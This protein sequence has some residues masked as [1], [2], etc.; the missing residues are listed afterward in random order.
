MKNPKIKAVELAPAKKEKKEKTKK[1]VEPA[2][3]VE[4]E[5]SLM[6]IVQTLETKDI[7]IKIAGKLPVDAN[8][9][10][11]GLKIYK[12]SAKAKEMAT[13]L[14]KAKETEIAAKVEAKAKEVELKAL[15]EKSQ[16][17]IETAKDTFKR[18]EKYIAAAKPLKI[19][20]RFEN[21][22]QARLALGQIEMLC[23]E[24]QTCDELK[25]IFAEAD[26]KFAIMFGNLDADVAELKAKDKNLPFAGL[27]N[28]FK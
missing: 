3:P 20:Y 28:K 18:I 24:F 26:N 9:N 25:N 16:K 27:S 19:Q 11:L 8:G 1:V 21:R 15:A 13:K 22:N 5:Q 17:A 7:N 6:P 12:T 23:T 14:V 4:M 10:I 2:M